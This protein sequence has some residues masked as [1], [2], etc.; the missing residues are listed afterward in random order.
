M[1]EITAK[2]GEATPHWAVHFQVTDADAAA[3]RARELGGTVLHGP[4]DVPG[5]G[6]LVVLQD[7]QGAAFSQLE[8]SEARP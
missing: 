1:A 2:G 7:P 5:L 4:A 8:P 3:A 6:R